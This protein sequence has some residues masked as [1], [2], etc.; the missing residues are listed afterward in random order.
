MTDYSPADLSAVC[1]RAMLIS[2]ERLNPELLNPDT[3]T[4]GKSKADVTVTS[5][6]LELALTV[7]KSTRSR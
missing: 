1:L 6:D 5:D 3:T 4:W 2:V 7:I